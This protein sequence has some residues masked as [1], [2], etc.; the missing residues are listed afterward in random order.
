M[1]LQFSIPKVN[2]GQ[3]NQRGKHNLSHNVA[4]SFDFGRVQ[5]VFCKLVTP[6]S[7]I[8]G[9]LDAK[10]RVM[11]MPLP[12]FG[13]L[14]MK[15]YGQFVSCQELMHS[16]PEFISGQVYSSS[17]TSY[18]PKH[19]P[20][21]FNYINP[22]TF[23]KVNFAQHVTFA[24]IL[25]SP[26]FSTWT[27][28]ACKGAYAHVG[29]QEIS[30]V[31]VVNLEDSLGGFTKAQAPLLVNGLNQM[32]FNKDPNHDE[33]LQ[34]SGDFMLHSSNFTYFETAADTVTSAQPD[35]SR[36]PGTLEY[37]TGLGYNYTPTGADLLFVIPTTMI[38]NNTSLSSAFKTMIDNK[39]KQDT[40]TSIVVAVS[41]NQ[42]GRNLL[43]ILK[44][45]GINVN[46]FNTQEAVEETRKYVSLMPL[47]AFYK[48]YFDIFM[49]TRD[50]QWSSTNAHRILDFLNQSGKEISD[51]Y[52]DY[53]PSSYVSGKTFTSFLFDVASSYA[54]VD[55][56]YITQAV[57]NT[58]PTSSESSVVTDY[59]SGTEAE[60]NPNS[61]LPAQYDT[62][63]SSN[64]ISRVGLQL[65]TRLSKFVNTNTVIGR[66]VNAF[67]KAHFGAIGTS[68]NSQYAGSSDVPINLGDVI[69]TANTELSQPGDFSGV[70]FGSGDY[71]FSY[72][73]NEFG[74]FI[75]LASIIPVSNYVQGEHYDNSITERFEF[76][77]PEFDAL[78]YD[79]LD[80]REIVPVP[81]ALPYGYKGN[82]DGTSLPV[83]THFGYSPRYTGYKV[84]PSVYSGSFQ[85]RSL[86]N[87]YLG[88]TL[89]NYI[90]QD[91]VSQKDKTY[92][93]EGP[94][95]LT[96]GTR[97]RFVNK[98]PMFSNYERIFYNQRVNPYLT[99]N[100]LKSAG[101]SQNVLAVPYEDNFVAY[102]DVK[103]SL[104]D[105]LKS[106]SNSYDTLEGSDF[107]V[108][109]Q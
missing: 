36:T 79:Y 105:H 50:I 86:R 54:S 94:V 108:N 39:V 96:C 15:L 61:V 16:F 51:L 92:S 104:I 75:V 56:N 62:S 1:P 70:G 52:N 13:V 57:D 78:G 83:H 11:P 69:V 44:H 58:T 17:S 19:V 10:I 40:N 41:F 9:S 53:A 30:N 103:C 66:N 74:Y 22:L 35:I 26:K 102:F 46:G 76:P 59:M 29:S 68:E 71:N 97:W 24:H 88:F 3:V 77:T 7:H 65:L 73:A 55:P 90:T 87:S 49:P 14:N 82:S 107:Y 63:T 109:K 6:D 12:P 27:A 20:R 31:A 28:Y 72:K 18:V 80:S 5:P 101:L 60:S 2:A 4:T 81:M 37:A 8:K 93:I 84:H 91:Y 48:A 95:D 45:L 23:D 42:Y 34:I 43:T 21:L 98:Y 38:K 32:C 33:P 47:L 85:I 99:L 100:S 106:I 64:V 25:C 89:D 67:L